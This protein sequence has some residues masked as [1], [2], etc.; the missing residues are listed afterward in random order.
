MPS[1]D[2]FNELGKTLTSNESVYVLSALRQDPLVWRTLGQSELLSAAVERIGDQAHLWSP[3][4][5]ALL[6]LGDPR[7]VDALRAEP[8]ALL[9]PGLQELALQAYQNLQRGA[10]APSTL[11]EAALLALTLR[12]RRRLTGTWVGMLAEI[13]PK[14]GQSDALWR[15]PL[16]ILYGLIPD[17]EEMLRSLL[18]KNAPRVA[19]LWAM[20]AQLSQPVSDAEHTQV[21]VRVLHGLPTAHQL[22]LLRSLSLHGR[23]PLAAALADHLLVNHPAFA[24]LRSQASTDGFDPAALSNRALALQQMGAFYQLAGDSSQALS[25]FD[26]AH[27]TLE[28]WFA[29]FSFK[30]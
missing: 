19:F 1:S 11:R 26:A 30:G 12:E 27:T 22:I 18:S 8:M 2:L 25:L 6:V 14:A 5:L 17:P 4:R 16:A 10:K 28:Q 29:V 23:E 9:G 21:F 13:M 15:T 24:A 3:A 20:H 7:S